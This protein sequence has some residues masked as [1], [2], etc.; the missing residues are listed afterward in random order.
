MVG[1]RPAFANRLREFGLLVTAIYASARSR[2]INWG[3]WS[4]SIGSVGRHQPVRAFGTD[5]A[6]A[7]AGQQEGSRKALDELMHRTTCRPKTK[8]TTQNPPTYL[9]R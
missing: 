1:P 4:R 2:V 9:K 6:D 3:D 8:K 5:H 7:N